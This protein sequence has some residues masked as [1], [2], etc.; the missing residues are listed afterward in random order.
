MKYQNTVWSLFIS[1]LLAASAT[2]YA[3]AGPGSEKSIWKNTRYESVNVPMNLVQVSPHAYYV[4]GPAGTPVDNEGFMSNA[5]VVITNEGVVVFDALGTPSL[6]YLLLSK[7]REI[8]DKPIVKVVVSHYHADHIYGLQV[9]KEQGA[10]IIAPNGAKKYLAS[11]TSKNRLKERRKSLFP[12]VDENTHIVPPDH[13]VTEQESFKLGG[14]DFVITPLGSTHSDGDMML[15]VKQDKVLF[16]GDLIFQGRIPF[17]AG[18]QPTNWINHLENLNV[19][20]LKVIVPGHGP[21]ST[22]PK[23]AVKFTLGYLQFLHSKMSDAVEN[24]VPFD[25]AYKSV[26]WS[27]YKKYPAFKANHMNAYY[28]YLALEA[29]SLN[30]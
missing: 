22:H 5:G 24:L 13:F 18:S 28:I 3:V 12:W 6:A 10:K 30:N 14:L 21:A 17:V 4:H 9:F 19:K 29:S 7:I 25:E 11:D 15:Y 2:T 27:M 16:S 20:G 1:V 23:E 26:D 8:T